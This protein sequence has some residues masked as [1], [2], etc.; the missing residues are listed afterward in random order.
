MAFFLGSTGFLRERQG[1]PQSPR[2]QIRPACFSTPDS[3]S[4]RGLLSGRWHKVHSLE[5]GEENSHLDGVDLE[6]GEGKNR[7][8]LITYSCRILPLFVQ[9]VVFWEEVAVC[10]IL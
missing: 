6:R 5:V 4:R 2:P 10:S 9:S 7:L 8:C 1:S 3:V